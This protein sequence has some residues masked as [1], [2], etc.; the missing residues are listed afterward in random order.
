[1]TSQSEAAWPLDS[2]EPDHSRSFLPDLTPNY[3]DSILQLTKQTFSLG[4]LTVRMK[5]P[6]LLIILLLLTMGSGSAQSTAGTSAQP[7]ADTSPERLRIEVSLVNLSF[8]VRDK[9]GQLITDLGQ[10]NFKVF[11]NNKLQEI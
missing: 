1:M 10:A 7:K 9:K 4:E 6:W 5:L 3:K 11:E 8:S 2:R